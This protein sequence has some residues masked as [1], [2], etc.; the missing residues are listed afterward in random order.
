M[1]SREYRVLLCDPLAPSTASFATS[2]SQWSGMFLKI[3]EPTLTYHYHPKPVI[4]SEFSL[5]VVS[6]M[7]LDKSI[8]YYSIL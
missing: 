4:T 6:S 7:G 2:V 1:F 3:D 8:H 5:G